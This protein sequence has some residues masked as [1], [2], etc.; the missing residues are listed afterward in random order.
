MLAPLEPTLTLS[1]WN[2]LPV[3][4]MTAINAIPPISVHHA[5]PLSISDKSTQPSIDVI[6]YQDTMMMESTLLPY[7]AALTASPVSL[8]QPTA[9]PAPIQPISQP[10]TYALTATLTVLPVSLLQLIVSHV[11]LRSSY[12]QPKFVLIA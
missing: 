3:S 7:P 11:F 1:I 5:V 9:S 10:P 2:A 12:Q 8:P 6:L 4:I